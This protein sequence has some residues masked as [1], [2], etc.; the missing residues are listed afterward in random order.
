MTMLNA[1]A[2]GIAPP[3]SQDPG[4]LWFVFSG[5]RLL[6]N[7]SGDVATIPVTRELE[8]LAV[9]ISHCLYLG[10]FR[11]RP[12]YAAEGTFRSGDSSEASFHELRSLFGR[13]EEGIYELALLGEHLVEWDKACQF[14]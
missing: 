6:V 13:L 12:C 10:L 9:D 5:Y 8:T 4:A 14:C 11:G 7:A 1:F 3:E 2:A